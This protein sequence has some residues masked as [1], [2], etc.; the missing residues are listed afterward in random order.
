MVATITSLELIG[1]GF[2]LSRGDI[3]GMIIHLRAIDRED[4]DCPTIRGAFIGKDEVRYDSP[5][6]A[7]WDKPEE[8]HRLTSALGEA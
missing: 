5:V 7:V 1:L 6:F 3:I 8:I 4:Y 2:L